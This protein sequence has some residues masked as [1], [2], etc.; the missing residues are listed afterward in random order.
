M[1]G[2]FATQSADVLAQQTGLGS[3]FLGA[4]LLAG[5]TSLPELSTTTAATRNGRDSMAISNV[6]GSNAFDV[7]LLFLAELLY[8][9]GTI[10][11]HGGETV[12]FV[13]ALVAGRR[14]A[15]TGSATS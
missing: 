1:G 10:I 15:A 7:S 14:S 5:A 9:G 13:A 8:R 4:T 12:V 2:W 3:A 11:E 6:F